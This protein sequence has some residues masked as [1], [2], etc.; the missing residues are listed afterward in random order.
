MEK[1]ARSVALVEQEGATMPVYMLSWL[2]G[3]LLFMR[4]S[5]VQEKMDIVQVFDKRRARYKINSTVY[6]LISHHKSISTTS[7]QEEARRRYTHKD[8]YTLV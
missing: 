4:V 5:D 1:T 8:V 6:K 7:P 3:L 2:Q